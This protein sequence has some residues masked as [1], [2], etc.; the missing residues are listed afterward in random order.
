M[1][2]T[3]QSA[4][5]WFGNKQPPPPPGPPPSLQKPTTEPTPAAQ[6]TTLVITPPIPS[7]TITPPNPSA[8]PL[9]TAMPVNETQTI[10][11]LTTPPETTPTVKNE[12]SPEPLPTATLTNPPTANWTAPTM[13]NQN[14]NDPSSRY[15]PTEQRVNLQQRTRTASPFQAGTTAFTNQPPSYSYVNHQQPVQHHFQYQTPSY[16]IPPH[17]LQN[18]MSYQLETMQQ[19]IL[20]QNQIQMELMQ[21]QFQQTLEMSLKTISETVARTLATAVPQNHQHNSTAPGLPPEIRFPQPDTSEKCDMSDYKLVTSVIPNPSKPPEPP[22]NQSANNSVSTNL[23]K[24][25]MME[26]VAALREPKLSFNTLKPTTDFLAWKTMM[27]L[28]CAKSS[29]YNHLAKMNEEGKYEF[30]E[31][32]SQEDSSTLFM[33]TYDALGA[34]SE[35]IIVNVGAPD[36]HPLLRQLEDYYLDVDTSVVNRQILLEE[37]DTLKRNGNETYH[38]FALRYLRK[39]KELELNKVIIP[40]DEASNSYKFL[41]GL[42]ESRINTEI[43]LELASKPEW[44]KNITIMEIAKKAQRYMRHFKTLDTVSSNKSSYS[45][46]QNDTKKNF[47]F[48]YYYQVKEIKKNH[49]QKD[50]RQ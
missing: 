20:Q 36:G 5:K 37:F 19:S 47:V 16:T 23:S 11:E 42:N 50:P 31:D 18:Q 21:Q 40:S 41:R 3:T 30:N 33:L 43:C 26:F 38:Q 14:D 24:N 48:F 22:L 35:K 6:P 17:A 28:K 12:S 32:I 44:Y 1:V 2:V 4:G 8:P 9:P 27:A 15:I 7:A 34:M 29:K 10:I 46:S 13:S 25:D 45:N 39:K 49:L